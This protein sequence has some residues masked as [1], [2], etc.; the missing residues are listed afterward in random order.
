MNKRIRKKYLTEDEKKV[1][2]LYRECDNV[3]F[4]KLDE[5][6]ALDCFAF[7][8]LVKVTSEVHRVDTHVWTTAAKGKIEATAFLK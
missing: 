1:L 2:E 4:Y 5:A 8:D 3:K 7:T 6:N